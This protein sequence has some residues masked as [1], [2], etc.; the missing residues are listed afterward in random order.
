MIT[1]GW[2][3]CPSVTVVHPDEAV[4]Q[5]VMLFDSVSLP[6][7]RRGSRRRRTPGR[8]DVQR[9]ADSHQHRGR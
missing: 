2:S 4:Q 1:V 6:R 3:V 8:E 9:P 7:V 5:N